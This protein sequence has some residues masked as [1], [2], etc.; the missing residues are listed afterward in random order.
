MR[1]KR[2]VSKGIPGRRP[3]DDDDRLGPLTMT[4]N[5]K[6]RAIIKALIQDEG[7]ETNCDA[8]R[9]VFRTHPKVKKLV[10]QLGIVY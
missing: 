7:Y 1:T 9:H 10:S 5:A 6:D 8:L 3:K 2:Q 4:A